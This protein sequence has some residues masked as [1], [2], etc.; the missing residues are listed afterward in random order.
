MGL[1]NSSKNAKERAIDLFE[2][3]LEVQ[4]EDKVRWIKEVEFN[5]K[6]ILIS[7][8]AWEDKEEVMEK[9]GQLKDSKIYIN[10]DLSIEDRNIQR[11]LREVAG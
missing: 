8:K 10:H 6:E 11:K 1:E 7:L 3:K 9:K 4:L 5:K 2:E